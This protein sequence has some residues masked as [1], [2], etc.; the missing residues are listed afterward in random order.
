[1]DVTYWFPGEPQSEHLQGCERGGAVGSRPA[2]LRPTGGWSCPATGTSAATKDAGGTGAFERDR[3]SLDP[4]EEL[5]G[6][7]AQPGVAAGLKESLAATLKE[8]PWGSPIRL[9]AHG[10]P[11]P[12][13][14]SVGGFVGTDR[15]IWEVWTLAVHPSDGQA[16]H[17]GAWPLVVQSPFLS[18][19]GRFAPRGGGASFLRMG[20]LVVQPPIGGVPPPPVRPST[21]VQPRSSRHH[22]YPEV[23]C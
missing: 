23:P 4:W 19:R 22:P 8:P 18:F 13:A 14:A 3:A 10:P 5:I 12:I 16:T 1:M 17:Q 2:G 21:W 20:G 15:P 9:V 7:E 11:D 6:G